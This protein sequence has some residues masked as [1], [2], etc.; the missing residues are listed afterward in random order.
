MWVVVPLKE[1]GPR[2]SRE[3]FLQRRPNEALSAD[4]LFWARMD[5]F[6]VPQFVSAPSPRAPVAAWPT[7]GPHLCVPKGVLPK[8]FL[9]VPPFPKIGP[10]VNGFL[11]VPDYCGPS[12]QMVFR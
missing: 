1:A 4:P 7:A 11:G 12:P 6:G 5:A 9:K 2:F 8:V 3:L 10:A